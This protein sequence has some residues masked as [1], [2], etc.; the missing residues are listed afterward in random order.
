MFFFDDFA[1][2][3][4]NVLPPEY[5]SFLMLYIS[6]TDGHGWPQIFCGGD[7][8]P[9]SALLLLLILSGYIFRQ[10]LQDQ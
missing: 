3:D 6:T 9:A 5:W 10:D 4:R 8:K 1:K 7:A 2:K